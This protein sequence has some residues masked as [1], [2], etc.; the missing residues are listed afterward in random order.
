VTWFGKHVGDLETFVSSTGEKSLLT[1]V[2]EE[3]TVTG[4]D[5]VDRALC[6]EYYDKV[7]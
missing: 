3:M 1:V 4:V 5:P 2:T 6:K 7:V